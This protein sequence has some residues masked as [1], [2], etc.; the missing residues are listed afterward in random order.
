MVVAYKVT[1]GNK[2]LGV[3]LGLALCAA[4]VRAHGGRIE[5]ANGLHGGAVFTV[6]LPRATDASTAKKLC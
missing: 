4:M 6:W 3:G 2:Q 5:A 1:G